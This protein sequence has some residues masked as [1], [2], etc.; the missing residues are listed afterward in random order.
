MTKLT[1]FKLTS[2]EL[3]IV[4]GVIVFIFCIYG[5]MVIGHLEHLEVFITAS[6][7]LIMVAA[8]IVWSLRTA[9]L[10]A[11]LHALNEFNSEHMLER[12]KLIHSL[13][14]A[15]EDKAQEVISGDSGEDADKLRAFVGYAENLAIGLENDMYDIEMIKNSPSIQ[16]DYE[17]AERLINILEKDA[18]DS[19][20]K[21]FKSLADYFKS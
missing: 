5:L 2:S 18:P 11:T 17:A 4:I 6:M 12:R 8:S 1:K 7:S 13:H 14:A 10:K 9:R 21:T 16:A 3:G 15:L 20:Y 19:R